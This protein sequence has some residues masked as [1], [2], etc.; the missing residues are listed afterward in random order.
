M[1]QIIQNNGPVLIT[2]V[3]VKK[4]KEKQELSQIG[5]DETRKM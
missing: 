5:G 1:R 2:S 3:E 4:E